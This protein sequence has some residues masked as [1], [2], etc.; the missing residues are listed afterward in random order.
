MQ[1]FRSQRVAELIRKELGYFILREIEVSGAL[2][3]ITEVQVSKK[4]DNA[5]VLVSVLPSEKADEALS[6]LQKNAGE[7]QHMLLKKLNIKPLPRIVFELDSG[8]EHAARVEKLL[9]EE[10]NSQE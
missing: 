4:L 1:F 10:H 6:V 9:L 2:V 8:L 7:L 3:T 5:A